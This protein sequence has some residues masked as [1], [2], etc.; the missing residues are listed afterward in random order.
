MEWLANFPFT[1][2]I[3]N[4]LLLCCLFSLASPAATVSVITPTRTTLTNATLP[5]ATG[6]YQL[7]ATAI[8]VS[9]MT[10]LTIPGYIT[11]GNTTNRI[12][13]DGTNVTRN[14]V[15]IGTGGD[16]LWHDVA[17]TATLTN[18]IESMTFF[19]DVAAGDDLDI[20]FDMYAVMN[21]ATFNDWGNIYMVVSTNNAQLNVLT[22]ANN[23]DS[24]VRLISGDSL[25]EIRAEVDGTTGFRVLSPSGY[26]G[27]GTLFLSDDGTYKSPSV[28][29]GASIWTNAAGTVR[30]IN[31]NQT[32]LLNP[33]T[34]SVQPL[35]IVGATNQTAPLLNIAHD[36]GGI[37]SLMV[38]K[39]PGGVSVA[40]VFSEGGL[41]LTSE[42]SAGIEILFIDGSNLLGPSRLVAMNNVDSDTVFEVS[43]Q[44]ITTIT[45]GVVSSGS[46]V[47]TIIDTINVLTNGESIVEARNTGVTHF[48]VAG[49]SGYGGAGDRFLSD[50]GTYRTASSS[51]TITYT[52]QF[53]YNAKVT[54]NA[55]T[56]VTNA[57]IYISGVDVRNVAYGLAASDETTALTTGTNKVRW[58]APHAMTLTGVRASLT[59]AQTAGSLLTIDINKNG[60]TVLSTKLSI[61]DNETTSVTAATPPVIS[62]SSFADDDIISV[63]VDQVGTSPAGLKITLLGLRIP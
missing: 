40:E 21:S 35:R 49:N 19:H 56:Y 31:T 17:G 7:G 6:G 45:S 18:T 59:T 44:G 55:D 34:A 30:L 29:A 39:N 52:N 58:R 27:A 25:F 38:L 14:G 26:S 1:M 61:D 63:D 24:G 28:P 37:S 11:L 16:T 53:V 54:F 48:R 23:T 62:V 60:T 5:Q 50:D 36:T 10:N 13:D 46:A 57:T 51:S 43:S 2:K 33:S 22:T 3:T 47:G 32:L 42:D 15:A 4:I 20:N 8:G 41:S 12:S 9:G